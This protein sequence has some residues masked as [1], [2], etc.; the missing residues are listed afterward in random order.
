MEEE[1]QR[2]T[3]DSGVTGSYMASALT[4]RRGEFFRESDVGNESDADGQSG[5]HMRE[6]RGWEGAAI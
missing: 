1:I 5:R 4:Q 2:E 3:A 6:V